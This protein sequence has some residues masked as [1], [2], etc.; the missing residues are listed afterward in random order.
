MS[1]FQNYDELVNI[2]DNCKAR[3]DVLKILEVG[4]DAVVPQNAMKDFFRDESVVFPEKVTVLGWGK[5]SVGMFNS[6][7]ENFTGEVLGGCL[8]AQL[9]KGQKLASDDISIAKGAHPIPD[10]STIKSGEKLFDIAK[11]FSEND[12]LV[13]LISGGGSS[14]FEIPKEVVE[15][16]S[17]QKIYKL[18]L[19]SGADIHEVNSIRRALSS[20]KGGGLAKAVYPARIINIII[21][22]VP[23]NNLEDISS[24]PTVMD[25]LRIKPYDVIEKYGMGDDF[26]AVLLKMIQNYE[27]INEQYFK[28]V[29]SHI[30]ADNKKATKAMINAG[31]AMGLSV[32]PIDGYLEGEA[33]N[34]VKGF[35]A[36][37]GEIII[38]GGETTV[39]VKGKGKGGRNQEFVLAGLKKI[40]NGVLASMGTDGIDG[41]TDV[42]G[43]IGD[44]GILHIA[45]GKG[46]DIDSYLENNN[47]YEF[48]EKCGGTLKTGATGT[49][50]ADICV[51]LK[52][53]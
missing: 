29:E 14:M 7:Y 34:A 48:F 13:C 52:N 32:T 38:G 36:T 22:D 8:I 9:E 44:K 37:P 43:A 11:G 42:A 6:F 25:P 30:I 21:S 50:V 23:G 26:G 2:E 53:R 20:S 39:T 51:Y 27:P 28:N 40:G 31:G 47:S 49:N 16:E 45:Q 41:Q 33:R 17:L 3:S 18:L 24:G 12:T 35:M 10:E 46:L 4:V 1:I 19:D 15:P 5:A